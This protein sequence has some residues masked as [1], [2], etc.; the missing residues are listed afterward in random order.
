MNTM[1]N[2]DKVTETLATLKPGDGYVAKLIDDGNSIGVYFNLRL[3]DQYVPLLNMPEGQHGTIT[4]GFWLAPTE[5]QRGEAHRLY[6][7]S[8]AIARFFNTGGDWNELGV[9]FS[10][11]QKNGVGTADHAPYHLIR[12][13][14]TIDTVE[15][16]AGDVAATYSYEHVYA[17]ESSKWSDKAPIVV[18]NESTGITTS[19]YGELVDD[20]EQ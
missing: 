2:D 9:L 15:T 12:S 8:D 13:Y 1:L 11:M 20:G 18:V 16:L 19:T 4:L 5:F 10:Q 14:L 7:L 3:N 17:P 6:L